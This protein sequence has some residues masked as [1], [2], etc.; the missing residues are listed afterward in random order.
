MKIVYLNY[1]YDSQ[2]DS[3]GASVHVREFVNAVR[4]YGHEIKSYNL[5]PA[6]ASPNGELR[7]QSRL[8]QLLKKKFRRYVAQVI[9]LFRNIPLFAREWRLLAA[10]EP[11]VLLIRYN[12]LNFSAILAA[13]IKRIPVVLE[14]N[15]PHAFERKR[16]VNDIWHIPCVPFLVELMVMKLADRIITVS[17][18]LK[19]YY[20][21]RNIAADKISVAANGVDIERFSPQVLPKPIFEKYQL[22]DK[23]VLGFIGSF[24]YWH[25]LENLRRLIELTTSKFENVVYLL[26]GDGPLK[27]QL[28]EFV[29]ES[30]LSE[31]V[32]LT[33]YVPHEEVPNYLAAM[34]VVLAPYP[35]SDFFYFSPLKIFEYMSAG[36]PVLASRLGQIAEMIEHGENGLLY[37]PDNLTDFF[38]SAAALIGDESLRARLGKN[39]RATILQGYTWEANAK[40]IVGVM[41][42]TLNRELVSS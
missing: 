39:A 21:E 16:L 6:Y 41:S 32:I 40:R 24:H 33:G 31:E 20:L 23:V 18:I 4:A 2:Q 14:V 3:V 27:N 9:Q 11:D 42:E 1:L 36:K 25:G 15:S 17:D 22:A 35:A 34:N 10:E 19:S 7:A 26:V 12:T 8:R 30:G 5:N 13:K 28:T 38:E 37:E 29:K